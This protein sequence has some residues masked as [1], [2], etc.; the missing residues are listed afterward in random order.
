MTQI[1]IDESGS[2]GNSDVEHFPYFVI[3]LV[4]VNDIHCLRKAFRRFVASHYQELM[5]MDKGHRMFNNGKFTE[6][7]GCCLS[8]AMKREFADYI[9]RNHFFDASFIVV[10]NHGCEERFYTNKNRSFNY[11]VKECLE[12]LIRKGIYPQ[13]EEYYLRIDNRN[14]RNDAKMSMEDYLSTELCIEDNLLKRI[15]VAYYD[16]TTSE[17]IQIADFFANLK[18]SDV[19][20]RN[21]S[22]LLNKLKSENY[23]SFTYEF[24]FYQN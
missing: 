10:K 13:K 20:K 3:S 11:L 4:R 16:S 24:P 2:L 14:V 6:M 21:Y 18:F 19:I 23:V 5:K 17:M 12:Y 8:Y 22:D 7:K 1:F 15:Q 9:A